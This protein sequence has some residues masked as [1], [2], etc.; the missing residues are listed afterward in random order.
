MAKRIYFIDGA[1]REKPISSVEDRGM[2]FADSIYE[3]VRAKNGEPLFLKEHLKRLEHGLREIRIT[4]PLHPEELE[5][6]IRK[7]LK[8]LNSQEA[9]IYIQITR[10]KEP[11]SH[12]PQ[13]KTKPSV[14]I[15]T[16]EFKPLPRKLFSK[17][18][19]LMMYPDIRWGRCDIKTTMLLP[20]VL[21]K[22]E[23]HEAGYF[24]TLF[25]KN[26]VVTE[27]TSSSFFGIIEGA[28]YTHPED[29]NILPSITREKVI[30]ITRSLHIEVIEQAINVEAI[31]KLEGAF[32]AGTTYDILPVNKIENVSVPI[33]ETVKMVQTEYQKLLDRLS[34]R[35]QNAHLKN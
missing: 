26:G 23:A 34:K 9:S 2:F 35:S 32:L 20:N 16:S 33:S 11:R 25:Y 28:L 13:K 4:P 29:N 19:S 18:V 12:L 1:F 7:S 6:I 5:K 3:V 15:I 22:I 17:G 30:E 14:I 31:E 24:D 27:S 8:K 10:G 21:G